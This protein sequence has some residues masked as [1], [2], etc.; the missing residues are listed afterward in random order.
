MEH[1]VWIGP[2]Q[3]GRIGP[4]RQDF[5]DPLGPIGSHGLSGGSVRPAVEHG[6]GR[7]LAVQPG[8]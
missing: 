7:G 2:E 3:A 4:Q 6:H 1:Q 8:G 5:W